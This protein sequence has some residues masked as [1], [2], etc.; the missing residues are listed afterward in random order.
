MTLLR[1]P[2]EDLGFNM[3]IDQQDKLH[4]YTLSIRHPTID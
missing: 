1:T 2:H 4:T 3:H